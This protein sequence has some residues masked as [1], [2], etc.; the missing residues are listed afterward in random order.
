MREKN[1]NRKYTDACGPLHCRSWRSPSSSIR[2]KNTCYFPNNIFKKG[3]KRDENE[4]KVGKIHGCL[5][6]A[7]AVRESPSS[8]LIQFSSHIQHCSYLSHQPGWKQMQFAEKI[9]QKMP[10]KDKKKKRCG[11]S[12][13]DCFQLITQPSPLPGCPPLFTINRVEK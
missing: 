10:K 12:F 3:Q 11:V 9:P 4:E 8:P 1:K 5:R 2:P 7:G 13:R 6:S